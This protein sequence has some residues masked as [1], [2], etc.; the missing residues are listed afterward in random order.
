MIGYPLVRVILPRQELK[1]EGAT[2]FFKVID[3]FIDQINLQKVPK[4]QRKA[5]LS[6]FEGPKKQKNYKKLIIGETITFISK[7]SIWSKVKYS[8]YIRAQTEGA[9]ILVS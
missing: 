2:V 3:G 1:P 5:I 9:T 7:P 6:L 8:I 4:H